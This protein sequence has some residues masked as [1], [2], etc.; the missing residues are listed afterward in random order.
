M[1]RGE[2]PICCEETELLLFPCCSKFICESCGDKQQS[3]NG[4]GECPFCRQLVPATDAE[5]ARA[6]T[7]RAKQGDAT[8]Q[9][10][11][12]GMYEQGRG[13][14]QSDKEAAAWYRKAADQGDADAQ[15][16]L[17]SMYFHGEGVEKCENEGMR[18]LGKA[19]AQGHGK[20]QAEI[21]RILQSRRASMAQPPRVS[22]EL[23]THSAGPAAAAPVEAGQQHC[24]YCGAV[25]NGPKRRC[26]RCKQACYCDA[27][28]QRAGWKEHKKACKT[29]LQ[30]KMVAS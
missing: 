28:C 8:A 4:K 29:P 17:G 22:A 10:N 13:V 19:K 12:G 30:R 14:A 21:E 1:T 2:C 18:W 3:A 9:F 15:F 6:Y 7:R 24:G 26:G 20:A 11:L 5:R 25:L 16:M 27:T 23:P